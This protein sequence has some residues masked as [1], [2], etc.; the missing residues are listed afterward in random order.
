MGRDKIGSHACHAE[1]SYSNGVPGRK[2]GYE[3]GDKLSWELQMV[4][5]YGPVLRLPPAR[6]LTGATFKVD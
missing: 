2:T 6:I 5:N 1:Q 3:V 4:G